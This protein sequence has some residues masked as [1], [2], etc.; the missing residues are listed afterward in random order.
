MMRTRI[1]EMKK[2]P[3]AVQATPAPAPAPAPKSK[4]DELYARLEKTKPGS[5]ESKRVSEQILET[6][7]D[8]HGPR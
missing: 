4:L 7:F 1:E 2:M 5:E 8:T 6:I 3:S